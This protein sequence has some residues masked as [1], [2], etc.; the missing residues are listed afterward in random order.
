MPT[1]PALTDVLATQGEKTSGVYITE[2]EHVTDAPVEGST[3]R[4]QWFPETL[5]DTKAINYQQKEIPGGSLPLYQWINSGERIISF[6]A[7]FTTDVNVL[8]PDGKKDTTLHTRLV[9][10]GS[11]RH[12]IDI[13]AAI[14]WLRRFMHPKYEANEGG[15]GVPITV[16]PRKIFLSI[17]NSGIGT[18]GGGIDPHSIY[19]IMNQCDVS[20][21]DMFPNGMPRVVSV[22]LSFVQV[23][24]RAG[25]IIF[26]SNTKEMDDIVHKDGDDT[27]FAYT[28]LPKS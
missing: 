9:D 24:Q 3:K 16:A 20:Y 10:E 14:I 12:N 19:A 17:P 11:A 6:T 15:K 22:Q 5:T 21:E 28:V 13:R 1:V 18:S 27:Y 4:F 8:D 23:A 26:P 2:L 25:A 7:Q